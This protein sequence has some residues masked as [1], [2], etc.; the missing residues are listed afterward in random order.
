[1]AAPNR[2]R[3]QAAGGAEENAYFMGPVTGMVSAIIPFH[4][5]ERFLEEAIQS[6]F[7]Q[8]YDRWELLLVD[9]GSRDGSTG[10]ALEYADRHPGKVCY[11]EHEGHQ[12]MGAAATRNLG[13]D[14]ARGEY[15]AMLDSDDVWDPPQLEEQVRLLSERPEAGMVYG[16]TLYWYSWTT[17]P[18][19]QADWLPDLGI[20]D[21]SLLMPPDLAVRW[22]RGEA[23]SA[24]PSSVLIRREALE[25]TG[26][27]EDS[28]R[29]VHDEWSVF[30]EICLRF[31]VLVANRRWG[32]YRQ[33]PDSLMAGYKSAFR[34]AEHLRF[35]EWLEEHLRREGIRDQNLWN[36]LNAGLRPYRHPFLHNALA[37][38]Q[39][40]ANQLTR[41]RRTLRRKSAGQSTG[42]IVARPNPVP[43]SDESPESVTS[44][45]WSA[46]GTQA[47]EVR[48]G[49][50]DGPLFSRSAADGSARTGNWLVDGMV[51][52]LQD[53]GSG[54][55]L[56]ADHSIATVRV[57]T[58][59]PRLQYPA[60]YRPYPV[61][62]QRYDA[63][64]GAAGMDQFLSGGYALRNQ[65]LAGWILETHPRRVF[66]FAA[67]GAG[68][69]L[70][71]EN[72][73]QEYV[74]S[75]FACVPVAAARKL[76]RKAEVRR[77]DICDQCEAIPW[78][79]FDTV[80]CISPGDIPDDLVVL[81]EVSPGTNVFLSCATLE[82]LGGVRTFPTEESVRERFA[83]L[84]EIVRLKAVADQ[85]I[86]HGVR[87]DRRR[88]DRE[89][90]R[91]FASKH[92]HYL[93]NQPRMHRYIA[94]HLYGR[95]LEIGCRDGFLVPYLTCDQYVGVDLC[96]RAIEEARRQCPAEFLVSD[97]SDVTYP[98]PVDSLYFNDVLCCQA[99]KV[100]TV[101]KY[102]KL[103]PS[104]IVV[105]EMEEVRIELPYK[106]RS[107]RRF[108]LDAR[109]PERFRRRV[110]RVFDR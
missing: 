9:D 69:A 88:P 55:G 91:M 101:G 82:D 56:T 37:Y 40:V 18:A 21:N 7:A 79:R 60:R 26:G 53:A 104:R 8:T 74:W 77:I 17:T 34:V 22:L 89:W 5:T 52:C 107:I 45:S 31:P 44:L 61:S 109:K 98:G 42:W 75:D 32:K 65:A 102:E 64:L 92:D 62:S 46:R 86:V 83:G 85:I 80:V 93:K 4:D 63:Q 49:A 97:W 20:P 50:P 71:L 14:H 95:V 13:F 10:I 41:L 28:F 3:E 23:H 94:R 58:L 27:C 39:P 19:A 24:I 87:K 11:L 105:Q 73:V 35:L 29:F 33:H 12:N 6:V 70:L 51:F 38:F 48:V 72:Q 36:T 59:A 84:L 103:K 16:N 96:Q 43:I 15:V 25:R 47:V 106:L 100:G 1:M 57:R 2:A 68:L 76:L 110:V 67:G 99:D 81:S 108:Y 54:A 66:E 30:F 90:R 78:G